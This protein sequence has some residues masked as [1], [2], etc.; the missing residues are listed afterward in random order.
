MPTTSFGW[1]KSDSLVFDQVGANGEVDALLFWVCRFSA[2]GGK[3]GSCPEIGGRCLLG[4]YSLGLNS[5]NL[6]RKPT[7]YIHFVF[8][9]NIQRYRGCILGFGNNEFS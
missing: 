6:K 5:K 8:N 9:T 1:P 2:S 4:I 7:S 3:T